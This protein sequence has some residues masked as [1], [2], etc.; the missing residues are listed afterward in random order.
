VDV[1]GE[2]LDLL[3]ML[4]DNRGMLILGCVW[5]GEFRNVVYFGVVFDAVA[6]FADSERFVAVV[7]TVLEVC[8]R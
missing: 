5:F 4:V 8:A 3:P 7:A 6:E 2:V 1:L